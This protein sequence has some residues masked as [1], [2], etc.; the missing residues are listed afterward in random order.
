MEAKTASL[1]LRLV[2]RLRVLKLHAD[3]VSLVLYLVPL[4]FFIGFFV[5]PLLSIVSGVV[6]FDWSLLM[7]PFY[8]NLAPVGSP[9]VVS[10]TDG[11]LDLTFQGVDLGVIL[12]SLVNA[13]LVTLLASVIGT[14]VA[15][16]V[17]LFDFPGRRLLIVLAALPLLVT[18]FVNMYVIRLLFGKNILG[19]T[20]STLL[21]MLGIPV[22][23]SFKGLAGITLAQTLAF[24]PI[25]Y[26]NVLAALGAVDA[27]LIEQAINL[28]A[29]GFRL[30]RTIVLPLVVP[31][32][33]AGATLVYI[34]SLEDVGGP[35]VFHYYN[36]M[37]YQV[38][39]FFQQFAA[40]GQ[41]GAAAALSLIMLVCALV[42]LVFVRRYLSLR[43]YARLARGAPRP[44]RRIRLGLVGRLVAYLVVMPIA[45]IAAAPQIGVIVLAFSSRWTG[46]FPQGFTL[47][48]Y[49][50]LFT[51]AGVVRGILNSLTYTVAAIAG[52]SVLG[53]AVGYAVARLRLPGIGFLDILSTSPLAVPGLVVAFGYF[54]YFHE[55][56]GGSIL[57]PLVFPVAPMVIAYIVRKI[58]FTVRSVYTGVIQTPSSLE[59]AAQSLGAKRASILRRIVLPLTWRSLVAGLLLSSIYVMSEVSVSVTL[60]AL[61]GD[62]TSPDHTGP[63]TFVIMRLIQAPSTISGCQPQAVAAAMATIL[64][65]FEASVLFVAVSRLARRGQMLISV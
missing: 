24:Y 32:I 25:V 11:K 44:L 38:F 10:F 3:P 13:V 42:P 65:L 4:G 30:I 23:V 64:M 61:G 55:F 19:N 48:N 43:Y 7:D 28:G 17:G 5:G 62:I 39:L 52:I 2:R 6:G 45:A 40:I 33:L 50:A 47:N 34:L 35:I 57:D 51:T 53:F 8:I 16:L 49:S 29:R 27:T 18:P 15:L 58:P 20:F 36:M 9:V 37:S 1:A 41:A 46:A 60:G 54:I 22:S 56:F 14:S 26:V 12:N 21:S 59:E 31:G 63:I